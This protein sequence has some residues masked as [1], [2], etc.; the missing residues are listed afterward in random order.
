M[1]VGNAEKNAQA[2]YAAFMSKLSAED[3]AW[4]QVD[5]YKAEI[6][7]LTPAMRNLLHELTV[8]VFWPH[9]DHDL[10]L[11][12]ALGQG[13]LALDQIE[14]PLGS[15]MYFKMG[16]DF[17]MCGMMV[18]TPRLQAQGAGR[19]LLRRIMRDCAG[20]DLRLSATRSGYRLYESAGFIP[21]STIWQHQGI[22]R[23]IRLPTP[24]PGLEI[25]PVQPQD[26]R[27]LHLL[28]RMA[29]GATRTAVMEAMLKASTGTV[30]LRGGEICGFALMRPFGKG[31]VIGPVVAEDDRMAM[32][33]VAPLIQQCQ[34]QFTRLDTPLQTEQFAAFLASAGMGVFDT[35]TE[36]R[37]GPARRA[38]EGAL[39]YGL[40]SHSLG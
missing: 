38:V 18:T 34:G 7:A 29:Y 17:A 25:R 15:A 21:V 8:G 37:I 39:T 14:R 27:T 22:A 6:R 16:E 10:D 12:L 2:R 5:T 11:F 3:E 32:Q 28:D 4:M 9:R 36:M 30:V 26:T 19:R 33:L 24:V 40:A 31:M 20:R 35:V 13:Y 1:T 23:P